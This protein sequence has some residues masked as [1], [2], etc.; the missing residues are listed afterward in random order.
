MPFD[1]FSK[2]LE[3]D[4]NRITAP[5]APMAPRPA[6]GLTG[7][8]SPNNGRP[9]GSGGTGVVK[10]GVPPPAPVQPQGQPP[11]TGGQEFG[12]GPYT[13]VSSLTLPPAFRY[14]P[15]GLFA[16]TPPQESPLGLPSGGRANL[17]PRTPAP[18]LAT[19]RPLEEE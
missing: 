10:P 1:Y 16:R 18:A 5:T 6:N 12:L 8:A 11:I 9:R 3:R 2:R 14:H 13:G 17:K 15:L 7:Q 19:T 4:P